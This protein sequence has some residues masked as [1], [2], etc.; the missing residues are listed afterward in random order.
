MELSKATSIM[1]DDVAYTLQY[2]GLLR[3]LD[4]ADDV[5]ALWCPNDA[6]DV[7]A[8]KHPVKPPLVDDAALHWTP[9]LADVKRDKFS[10]RAK[11][12]PAEEVQGK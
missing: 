2:L 4:R 9:F 6:L 12:P 7:L 10:I 11:K 5:A 3:R 8:R 1:A